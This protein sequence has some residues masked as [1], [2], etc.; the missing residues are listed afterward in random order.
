MCKIRYELLQIMGSRAVWPQ[1][2]NCAEGI[3][4]PG[5]TFTRVLQPVY[6]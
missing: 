4:T 3:L 6:E 2:Y 5:K 1:L